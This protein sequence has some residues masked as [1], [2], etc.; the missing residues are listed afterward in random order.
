MTKNLEISACGAA[1]LAL[2]LG[3]GGAACARRPAE[4]PQ[5]PTAKSAPPADVQSPA[6]G[7][8]TAPEPA[9]RRV[10]SRPKPMPKPKSRVTEPVQ[11]SRTQPQYPEL[12]R[13][14]KIEGV[15]VL[16]A[17]VKPDGTVADVKLVNGVHP[18]LDGAAERAVSQWRYEPARVDG[19]AVPASVR[20]TVGFRL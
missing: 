10:A 19:H 16:K 6:A 7:A 14:L 15:V 18:L 5:S 12:A 17:T 13:K 9:P 2:V 4:T 1:L 20:V 11:I 3:A 8:E